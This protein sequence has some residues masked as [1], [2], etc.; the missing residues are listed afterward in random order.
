MRRQAGETSMRI[1]V[2]ITP[3]ELFD[4]ITIL[5]IKRERFVDPAQRQNVEREL[6]VLLAARDQ[7]IPPSAQLERLVSALRSVNEALWQAEDEL[8]RY[9]RRH[10]FG[11]RFVELARSVYQHNDRRSAL[12]R[13]I[14]DLLGSSWQ[15]EKSYG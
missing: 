14:N 15:E 2:E 12:K 11:P 13:R 1:L 4:K 6:A 10:D 5:Q 7:S 8:R 3:A 9:E